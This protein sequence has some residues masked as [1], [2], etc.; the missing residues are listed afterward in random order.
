[1]GELLG[2][3]RQLQGKPLVQVPGGCQGPPGICSDEHCA[4]DI[5]DD[6]TDDVVEK[7]I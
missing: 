5:R 2:V 4:P 1:L 3:E 7:P 6:G